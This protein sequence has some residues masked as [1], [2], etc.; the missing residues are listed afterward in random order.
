MNPKKFKSKYVACQ[1]CR[2]LIKITHAFE[3]S[4]PSVFY[5]G[6]KYVATA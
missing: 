3:W 1:L 2:I 5:A 4:L 6:P